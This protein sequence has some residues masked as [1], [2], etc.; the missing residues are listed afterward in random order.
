ML[1]IYVA[2]DSG[3]NQFEQ[4]CVREAMKDFQSAFPDIKVIV[5]GSEPWSEGDYSS[6]DW[7]VKKA[8][9]ILQPHSKI[10]IDADSIINMMMFEPWQ[11]TNPHIDILVTQYDIAAE[12]ANDVSFRVTRGRIIVQSVYRYRR[13]KTP[14]QRKAI[15]TSLWGALLANSFE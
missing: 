6:A 4:T 3:L 1:P 15:K 14:T 7:Y 9:K 5:F 10:K 12:R 2:Y 8:N 11:R 13:L